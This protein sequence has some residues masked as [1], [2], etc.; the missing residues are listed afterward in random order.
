[1]IAV[2]LKPMRSTMAPPK[3][4]AK[5]IGTPCTAATRPVRAALPV[6]SSTNQGTATMAIIRLKYTIAKLTSN[7]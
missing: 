3:I 1:M 5:I 6:V 4:P 2:R 7:A